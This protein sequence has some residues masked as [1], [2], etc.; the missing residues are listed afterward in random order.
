[1]LRLVQVFALCPIHLMGPQRFAHAICHGQAA[2]SGGDHGKARNHHTQIVMRADL[3]TERYAQ[4]LGILEVAHRQGDLEVFARMHAI[5]IFKVSV[6][7]ATRAPQKR[8]HFFLRRNE[9]HTVSALPARSTL[10][11]SFAAKSSS[12]GLATSYRY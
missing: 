9:F 1:M 6:A 11:E 3:S 2:S 7:Q 12:P 8:D 4:D 10:A 5:G